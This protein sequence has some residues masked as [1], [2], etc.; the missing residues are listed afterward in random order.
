M[1]LTPSKLLRIHSQP[2]N[3]NGEAKKKK[4]EQLASK[5]YWNIGWDLDG[6]L[7]NNQI[8]IWTFSICITLR[9]CKKV[10]KH[11]D[12]FIQIFC[13]LSYDMT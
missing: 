6:R 5:V 2:L 11:L 13:K 9:E 7:M 1:W 10:I 3:G 8:P 12:K 4:T